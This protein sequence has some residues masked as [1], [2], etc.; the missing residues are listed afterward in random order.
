D[1]YAWLGILQ[2]RIFSHLIGVQL[3]AADIA[4]RSYEVGII[5][6]TPTPNLCGGALAHLAAVA[7]ACVD[8]KRAL[9]TANEIS[10]VFQ[11]PALLQVAGNTLVE[12]AAAWGRRLAEAEAQLAAHQQ[13]IDDIAFRLYGIEGEDRRAIEE[14][15]GPHP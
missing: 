2:S 12:R 10:H 15:A 8:L 14:G 4:A 11:R 7:R 3:A 1:P 6:S 13:E 5:E 9:D